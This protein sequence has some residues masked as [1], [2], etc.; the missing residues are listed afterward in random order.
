MIDF[1]II[2]LFDDSLCL[3][4]LERHLRREGLACPHCDGQR[5]LRFLRSRTIADPIDAMCR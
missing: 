1:P 4:W 5:I 3:I 2:D